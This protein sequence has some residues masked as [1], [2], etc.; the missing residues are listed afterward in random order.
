SGS[1]S[2]LPTISQ[3]AWPSVTPAAI[4]YTFYPAFY[5]TAG[6]APAVGVAPVEAA[7]TGTVGGGIGLF[8]YAWVFG[9]GSTAST[10]N[11]TPTYTGLGTYSTQLT[12]TDGTGATATALAGTVTGNGPVAAAAAGTAVTGDPPVDGQ[13]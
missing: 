1:S 11:A 7:F 4:S 5:V 8:T 2:S 6:V 12:V 3:T 10:Q 13:L 9:D